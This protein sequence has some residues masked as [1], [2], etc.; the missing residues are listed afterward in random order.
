M[1][2]KMKTMFLIHIVRNSIFVAVSVLGYE[3]SLEDT[4]DIEKPLTAST[5][6]LWGFKIRAVY[7]KSRVIFDTL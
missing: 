5:G 4:I 2:L 7:F 3:L 6:P 1:Y